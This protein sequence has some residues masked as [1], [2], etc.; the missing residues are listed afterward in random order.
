MKKR[1][2]F[3][4]LLAVALAGAA[5]AATTWDQTWARFDQLWVGST[6]DTP[7]QTL[8]TNGA[9]IKGAVEIDGVL[10]ADGGVNTTSGSISAT[11]IADV[12][13][14]FQLPLMSFTTDGAAIT[15]STAPGLEVDDLIPN[16]VWAD[17]ETTPIQISFRVPDDYASGGA[18][19]V[20]ATESDSTTPNQVDFSV[21]VNSD[22]TAAD[23]SATNQTPVALVGTT[24]TPDEVTLTVVTDFSALAAG[25]WVTLNV[26]RDDVATGTGDLEIKGIVFYYTATQ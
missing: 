6:S 15:A 26:W 19:K 22:G 3:V 14:Y 7:T 1:F 11:E 4:L 16:I 2:L 12:V 10:Y 21:Y 18:F 8:G 20:L 25:K 23:S 9:Y 24:S 5:L 17:E 13:R